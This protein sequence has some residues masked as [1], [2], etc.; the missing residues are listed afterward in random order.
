MQ[1]LISARFKSVFQAHAKVL[2][3][4]SALLGL[5]CLIPLPLNPSPALAGQ[6][7]RKTDAQAH[8][9]PNIILITT[10]DMDVA[11]LATMP[12]TKALLA[13]EGITFLESYVNFPVGSPSRAS[14]LTGLAAHNHGVVSNSFEKDNGG[15]PTF[16]AN[17]WEDKNIGTWFQNGGYATGFIGRIMDSYGDG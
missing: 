14:L 12:K 7:N 1:R 17:G 2:A 11:S 9:P 8:S 10:D 5:A 6:S 16:V 4:L 13:D 15:F 3:L